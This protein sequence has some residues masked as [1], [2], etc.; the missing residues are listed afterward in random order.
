MSQPL[1]ALRR[2][3]DAGLIGLVWLIWAIAMTSGLRWD[4]FATN[5]FMSVTMAFGSFVAGSTSM[6]GGAI[7]FPVMTLIFEIDPKNARDFSLM[8]QSVG[9][10]SAS[11]AIAIRRIPVDTTVLAICGVGG[12]AGIIIGLEWV[13]HWFSATSVK[14]FFVALWSAFGVALW[15]VHHLERPVRHLRLPRRGPLTIGGLFLAGTLGGIITGLLGS[16]LDI[17][18]FALLVLGFRICEKVATPTSV[19]LMATNS[20][21]GFAWRMLG[22]GDNAAPIAVET[23]HYWW[24][25]VPV[26]AIGAPAGA[27]FIHGRGHQFIVNLL[28]T[29]IIL[30]F[31]AALL[32]IP[33]NRQLLLLALV[34]FSLG[35]G[36]FTAIWW[37]GRRINP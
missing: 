15:R 4:L 32:I 5:W 28:I 37:I 18:I 6:G 16:G 33:M 31:L 35:A 29:I 34:T 17:L 20:L 30:Q 14:V 3:L 13:Q 11:F 23:W 21:A 25:A 2:N 10:T 22:G 27:R 8:I 19:I 24:V 1:L 12:I 7:A 36:S 26:V 9:M